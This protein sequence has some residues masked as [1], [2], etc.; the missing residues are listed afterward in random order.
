MPIIRHTGVS[1]KS[2]KE[3]NDVGQFLLKER[4]ILLTEE[5]A[6]S[7]SADLVSKLLFLDSKSK[8]KE[9]K[10]YINSPG[11]HVE[12]FFSIY[13]TI[14]QISAPVKTICIG[15]AMS[16]A[17][18]LLVSGTKGKRLASP[19]SLIMIHDIQI[20][21]IGGSMGELS[22][23]MGMLERLSNS[24]TEVL[25]RHSGQSLSKLRKDCSRDLYLTAEEALQYGLIDK[26]LK[27]RKKIPELKK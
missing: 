13:D 15:E 4:T 17:A 5:I 27:P 19:N 9:I 23:Q 22:I 18:G 11:G 8:T 16:A 12:C 20:S 6:P 21:E 14:Q 3:D 26:I 1:Q 2:D 25:A 7:N 10:L 24:F